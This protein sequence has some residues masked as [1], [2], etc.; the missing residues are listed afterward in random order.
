MQLSLILAL[1]RKFGNRRVCLI[2]LHASRFENDDDVY[3]AKSSESLM[4]MYKILNRMTDRANC[5]EEKGK[6]LADKTDESVH[7]LLLYAQTTF[8]MLINDI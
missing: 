2:Y 8:R 5:S 1:I 6:N 3:Y 7:D 4:S